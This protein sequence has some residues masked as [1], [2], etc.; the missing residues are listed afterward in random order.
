MLNTFSIFFYKYSFLIYLHN[1]VWSLPVFVSLSRYNNILS[2]SVY[3]WDEAEGM[4]LV[5]ALRKRSSHVIVYVSVLATSSAR[6][7]SACVGSSVL[8][9]G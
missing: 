9:P 4:L 3:V 1:Y 5:S 6:I 8:T 2:P 7:R